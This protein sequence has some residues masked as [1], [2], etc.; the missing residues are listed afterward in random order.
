MWPENG[1]QNNVHRCLICYRLTLET[2]QCPLTGD[3]IK[4][5]AK[6]RKPDMKEYNLVIYDSIYM[7]FNSKQNPLTHGDRK[8]KRAPTGDRSWVT[9]K[10]MQG[11]IV[12]LGWVCTWLVLATGGLCICPSSAKQ[13]GLWI[14]MCFMLFFMSQ[15]EST[16]RP[17]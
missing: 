7:K 2:S 8:Q 4:H 16:D 15:H 9:R 5:Y 13:I 1:L 14:L 17:I 6:P 12:R 11:T 3:W 10:A